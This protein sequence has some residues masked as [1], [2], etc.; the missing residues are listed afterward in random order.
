[1]ASERL[2]VLEVVFYHS[3]IAP[4][5][6]QPPFISVLRPSQIHRRGLAVKRKQRRTVQCLFLQIAKRE[7]CV[8]I[9]FNGR[10]ELLRRGLAQSFALLAEQLV[11]LVLEVLVQ[12][13]LVALLQTEEIFVLVLSMPLNVSNQR[14]AVQHIDLRLRTAQIARNV[15]QFSHFE[16]SQIRLFPRLFRLFL[17]ILF[18]ELFLRVRVLIGI[19]STPLPAI[20]FSFSRTKRL[21][22]KGAWTSE[23]LVWKIEIRFADGIFVQIAE[24]D[25]VRH[26]HS[27]FLL[28]IHRSPHRHLDNRTDILIGEVPRRSTHAIH[29]IVRSV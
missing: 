12:L 10:N 2:V 17:E 27:R 25:I 21:E 28:S 13:L 24:V 6:T 9:D 8:Q 5:P 7:R 20:G 4:F 19:A 18:I 14:P 26:A 16:G 29:Q 15:T 23:Y 1:M 22:Q 11:H 3:A